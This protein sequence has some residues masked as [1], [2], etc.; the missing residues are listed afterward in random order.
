M[1]STQAKART[2][3]NEART[4]SDDI[5]MAT[6]SYCDTDATVSQTHTTVVA[7]VLFYAHRV[8]V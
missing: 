7:A 2:V 1:R 3:T 4:T 8:A 5:V 6:V